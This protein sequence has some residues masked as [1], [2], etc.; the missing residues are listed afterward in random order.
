MNGDWRLE[1]SLTSLIV[2]LLLGLVIFGL[3]YLLQRWVRRRGTSGTFGETL[4]RLLPLIELLTWGAFIVYS[5]GLIFK[6]EIFFSIALFLWIIVGLVWLSWFVIRDWVAGLITRVRKDYAVNAVIHVGDITGTVRRMGSLTMDV[7]SSEGEITELPYSLI[8]GQV[9]R[10]NSQ[11]G[12]TGPRQL[13]VDV[14]KTKHTV[15]ESSQRLRTIILSAPWWVVSKTPQI[16]LLEETDMAY[17]YEIRLPVISENTVA[18]LAQYLSAR[19][20]DA[21]VRRN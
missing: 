8:A 12:E 1:I 9:R 15:A 7:E 19:F 5:L 16:R 20:S 2:N 17:R 18:R 3:L 21:P 13:V 4:P 6:N 11:F 14:P 10:T